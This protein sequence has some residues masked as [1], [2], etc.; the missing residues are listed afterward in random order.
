[1]RKTMLTWLNTTSGIG[2][3]ALFH[4]DEIQGYLIVIGY[5]FRVLDIT[6]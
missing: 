4:T 5:N 3:T 6:F 2:V 1:M